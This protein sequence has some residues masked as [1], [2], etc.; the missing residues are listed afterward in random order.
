MKITYDIVSVLP[1]RGSQP[2]KVFIYEDGEFCGY[3]WMSR[4]DLYKNIEED[5]KDGDE[6]EI[7]ESYKDEK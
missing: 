3:L 5:D 2:M 4:D 6:W 7:K 1:H